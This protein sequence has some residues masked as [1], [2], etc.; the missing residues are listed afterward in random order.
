MP[1]QIQRKFINFDFAILSFLAQ[2]ISNTVT[3]S[4][5]KYH[6]RPVNKLS[7]SKRASISNWEVVKT[8]VH[9]IKIPMVLPLLVCNQLVT[10]FLVKANLLNDYFRKQFTTIGNYSC[11]PANISLITEERLCTFEFFSDDIVKTTRPLDPNKSHGHDGIS[12]SMIKTCASS[13]STPLTVLS[14]SC[15]ESECFH[16]NW[17]KD[18]IVPVFKN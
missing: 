5:L 14:M 6:E 11:I 2:D 12:L 16:K 15:F 9:C 4:K 17:K 18:K 8:F 13:I 3:S 1:F 10:D 7:N